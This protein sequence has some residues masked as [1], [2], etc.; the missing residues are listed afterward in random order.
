MALYDVNNVLIKSV[1][2]S[3]Y[4]GDPP[5]GSFRIYDIGLADLNG[6]GKLIKG[7]QIEDSLGTSQPALYVDEIEL[8]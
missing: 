5:V 3:N 8:R 4:G 6:K 7:V 1:P 2:L